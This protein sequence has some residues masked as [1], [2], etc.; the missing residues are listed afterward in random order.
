MAS[1]AQSED[2]IRTL[3]VVGSLCL[4]TDLAMGF[5]FEHGFQSAV[6]GMRLA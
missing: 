1:R 2:S 4:A 5:P 3:E 6:V